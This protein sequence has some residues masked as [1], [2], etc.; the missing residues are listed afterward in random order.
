MN[1]EQMKKLCLDFRIGMYRQDLSPLSGG[2]MHEM[3][4]FST[5]TGHFVV[6]RLNQQIMKRKTA[7][8]NF[9]QSENV[10]SAA[11]K[12][13]P[14]LPALRLDGPLYAVGE[15]LSLVPVNRRTN[16]KNAGLM[17]DACRSHW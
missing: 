8:A 1:D 11:A 6:K 16:F 12:L 14:A 10:A 4:R 17:S 3:F 7:R 9:I 5:D 15:S 13:L 2:L